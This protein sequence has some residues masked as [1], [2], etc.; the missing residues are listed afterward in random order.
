MPLNALPPNQ[1]KALVLL[2]TSAPKSGHHMTA[3]HVPRGSAL[4]YIGPAAS[5]VTTAAR[6]TAA[7]AL[8]Q[9]HVPTLAAVG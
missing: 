3:A 2:T 8:Q 1:H 7:D 4:P 9:T 6:R 5:A